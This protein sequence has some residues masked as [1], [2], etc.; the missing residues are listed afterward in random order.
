MT[1][2][3]VGSNKLLNTY[4][5]GCFWIKIVKYKPTDEPNN[6]KLE[7]RGNVIICLTL[8]ICCQHKLINRNHV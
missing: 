4:L 7:R 6:Y 1:R 3:N 8:K 2:L 5:L